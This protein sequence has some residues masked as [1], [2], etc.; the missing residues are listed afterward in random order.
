MI[1]APLRQKTYDLG[2]KLRALL[3]PASSVV[4]TC[5]SDIAEAPG[6]FQ[7]MASTIEGEYECRVTIIRRPS[8]TLRPS[9]GASPTSSTQVGFE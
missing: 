4:F 3:T 1:S 5:V 8:R 9:K 6:V 2:A 7:S